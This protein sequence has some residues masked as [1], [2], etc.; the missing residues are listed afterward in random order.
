MVIKKFIKKLS[1]ERI[2][3]EPVVK[4]LNILKT[5]TRCPETPSKKVRKKDTSLT[6]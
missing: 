4:T 3:E 1:R 2:E 5:I 6:Y